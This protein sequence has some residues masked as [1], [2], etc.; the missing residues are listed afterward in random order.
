M[1]RTFIRRALLFTATALIYWLIMELLL[2]VLRWG[3]FFSFFATAVIGTV[4]SA[5]LV[6]ALGE[7]LDKND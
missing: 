4:A 6:Y 3:F 1:K 2:R 7:R 5:L